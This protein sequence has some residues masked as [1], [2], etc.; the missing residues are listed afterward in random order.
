MKPNLQVETDDRIAE[1]RSEDDGMAEHPA[2]AREPAHCI[3][4]PPSPRRADY[5]RQRHR[6]NEP[7]FQ[8][9]QYPFDVIALVVL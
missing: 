1:E 4:G 2:K 9:A 3:P 6:P 5:L 8:R 7:A